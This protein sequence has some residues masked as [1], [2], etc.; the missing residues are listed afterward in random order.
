MSNRSLGLAP[1]LEDYLSAHAP[2][3]PVLLELAVLTA[4]MEQS[5][6]QIGPNQA[7][8]MTWLVKLIGA[9]RCIEVGVFT[10]YSSLATALALPDDGYLLACDIDEK[11]TTI[12]QQHWKKAG[13]ANKIELVLQPATETLQSRIAAGEAETYDFAFIDAD[14]EAYEQYYELCLRLLRKRGVIAFDNMLWGGSVADKTNNR[15]STQAIRSINDKVLKDA[16]VE[17][18]LIPVGDGILLATKK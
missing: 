11:W 9:R 13:V 10:G 18:S 2:A 15:T 17:C 3:H 8:F 12:A 1:A 6:M 14:K 4:P 5:G 16:R 7:A